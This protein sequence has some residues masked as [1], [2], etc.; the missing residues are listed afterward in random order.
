MVIKSRFIVLSKNQ[1]RGIKTPYPTTPPPC[2]Y[3]LRSPMPQWGRFARLSVRVAAKCPGRRAGISVVVLHPLHPTRKSSLPFSH[4]E[5]TAARLIPA[6][7]PPPASDT[8]NTFANNLHSRK[9]KRATPSP[10]RGRPA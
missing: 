10:T 2:K 7:Q 6:V 3:P 9:L 1:R 5:R 4:K 8:P